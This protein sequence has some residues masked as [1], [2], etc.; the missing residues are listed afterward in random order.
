[1]TLA[2]EPITVTSSMVDGLLVLIDRLANDEFDGL[3]H[4]LADIATLI[5]N[6]SSA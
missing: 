5:H 6:G 1:M 3:V 2:D 4:V